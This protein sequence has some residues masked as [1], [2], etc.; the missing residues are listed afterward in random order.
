MASEKLT[1]RKIGDPEFFRSNV[2]VSWS[3]RLG[4]EVRIIGPTLFDAWLIIEFDTDIVEYCERPPLD[5]QLLPLDGKV[6]PID[7]WV[8]R[9]SGKL[10]NIIV[11]DV[12][13]KRDRVQPLDLLE[14]SIASA[15]V[16]C[17]IWI[18]SELQRRS[19]LIRSYK[20]LRPF[21]SV[22]EPPD[23]DLEAALIAHLRALGSATWSQLTAIPRNRPEANVDNAIARLIHSGKFLANLA[24]EPLSNSTVV[25]LPNEHR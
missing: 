19:T 11:H 16:H 24:E 3:P 1:P 8:R 17:E 9:R 13:L 2:F 21:V 15:K 23:E 7:F 6:R 18:A 10:V 4:R 22:D 5:L 25:S 12:A 20:A 14:R